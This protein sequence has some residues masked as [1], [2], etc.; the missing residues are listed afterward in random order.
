MQSKFDAASK[1]LQLEMLKKHFELNTTQIVEQNEGD[2]TKTVFVSSLGTED[3]YITVD[4]KTDR[5]ISAY[6]NYNGEEIEITNKASAQSLYS[7]AKQAIK[8]MD[9]EKQA[10]AMQELI[11]MVQTYGITQFT[12]D[13]GDGIETILVDFRNHDNVSMSITYDTKTKKATEVIALINGE[14]R[15]ITDPKMVMSIYNAVKR[16]GAL[17]QGKRISA[18]RAYDR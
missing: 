11:S 3:L 2:G 18:N 7:I 16:Q 1:K 15:V 5:A 8:T 10:A 13:E 6:I 4:V 14:Q 9:K 12:Q 17:E